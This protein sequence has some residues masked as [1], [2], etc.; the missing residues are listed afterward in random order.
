[1]KQRSKY[2]TATKDPE[3]QCMRRDK[4]TE[5]NKKKTYNVSHEL[6]VCLSVCL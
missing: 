3:I 6:E 2:V 4:S 1:M 5:T